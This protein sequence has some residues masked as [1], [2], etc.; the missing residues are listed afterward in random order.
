MGIL[1]QPSRL[2]RHRYLDVR[3]QHAARGE[4]RRGDVWVLQQRV[5]AERDDEGGCGS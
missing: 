5:G 1:A 4:R 3:E 2:E